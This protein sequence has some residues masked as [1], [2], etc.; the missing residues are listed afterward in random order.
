MRKIVDENPGV[1]SVTSAVDDLSLTTRNLTGNFCVT[2]GIQGSGCL[3]SSDYCCTKYIEKPRLMMKLDD[4]TVILKNPRQ[5]LDD[6]NIFGGSDSVAVATWFR[7]TFNPENML[8]TKKVFLGN[9]EF[10]DVI[11]IISTLKP[12]FLQKIDYASLLQHERSHEV[13]ELEQWKQAKEVISPMSSFRS[14]PIENM[15]HLSR[16][17]L[18]FPG[19]SISDAIKIR[20]VSSK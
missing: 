1:E 11:T 5:R 7:D 10:N 17:W 8:H 19:L 2:Y 6:L 20:D 18:G 16:F 15:F 12:G 13:F 9:L 14:F 4:L 3:I